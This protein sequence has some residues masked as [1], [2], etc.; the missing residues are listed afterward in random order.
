MPPLRAIPRLLA[1]AAL[2]AALAAV[3][4]T[5]GLPP[6]DACPAL[7]G[8]PRT[9]EGED[10][11]LVPL[12]EGMALG[13]EDLPALRE[14]LPPE[15]WRYREVFFFEGMRMEIG[16]C[17][18]RYPVDRWYSAATQKYA[19]RAWLD[20][21]GNL[22]D[23][24]AGVPFPPEGI[25]P[26]SPQAGTQW[27]WNFEHRYRG[28]GPLGS[29]R[30]LDLPSR[31]GSP[32]T[33]RGSFFF[34]R[35]GHRSDLSASGYAIFQG[36]D[37]LWVAGG[38]FLEPFNARYLAW[39]QMRPERAQHRYQEP[40]D[41]FVYVP[42]MRKS[43][44]AA[45]AWVDGIYTPSYTVSGADRGGGGI[46][47]GGGNKYGPGGSVQPNSGASI[48]ITEDIRKG[49]VGLA[50]RP[51]A[52]RWKLR[53]ERDVLAPLNGAHP[54]YPQ[55]PERNYGPGGLSVASDRWEVRHA[56]VLEGLA[57]NVVEN[58]ARVTLYLDYQSLQP[59]YWIG[60]QPDRRILEVGILV[61]RFSGDLLDY[62]P[63]PGRGRAH[64]FD[65]VAAVFYFPIEGGT[66]WR[67]E[68]YD[69]V[70]V[71]VDPGK[72]KKL[73]STDSLLKGR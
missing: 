17:H 52:Y 19:Q 21:E 54:G 55:N 65:P 47:T 22:H 70:S 14:L 61:H 9:G 63:W 73:I 39:R 44:R 10:A 69:A 27:A 40:D 50:I 72:L 5:A 68:S 45:S 13:H 20:D 43:R 4:A 30:L 41:T 37:R 18:R 26:D 42:T 7:G 66:G 28:A 53:G 49:F 38:R 58:L 51:N 56:V 6:E 8:G 34:V 16:P 60:R 35:T 46:P 57:R 48:A 67:R 29:F 2:G 3:Q 23:Y 1:L 62:A 59:L 36:E 11:W 31:L 12:R 15:L 24:V 64:L 32:E 25:D 71:P 33:Y